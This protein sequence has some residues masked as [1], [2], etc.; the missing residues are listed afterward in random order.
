MNSNQFRKNPSYH[1]IEFEQTHKQLKLRFPIHIVQIIRIFITIIHRVV[2]REIITL[3]L[4]SLVPQNAH[5][6]RSSR[7]FLCFLRF[8]PFARPFL[9]RRLCRAFFAFSF[10]RIGTIRGYMAHFPTFEARD[11]LRSPPSTRISRAIPAIRRVPRVRSE[12]CGIG[13]RI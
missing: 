9:R 12:E 2:H 7:L 3:S 6:P 13:R 1:R 10:R 8:L 11:F 4:L 5:F